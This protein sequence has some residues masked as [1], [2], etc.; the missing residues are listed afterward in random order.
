ISSSYWGKVCDGRAFLSN[1]SS[2]VICRE[3]VRDKATPRYLNPTASAN[4]LARMV[5]RGS[6]DNNPIA[7]R[8]PKSPQTRRI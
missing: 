3:W 1:G 8:L 5:R 7:P 4:K 2:L 6:S